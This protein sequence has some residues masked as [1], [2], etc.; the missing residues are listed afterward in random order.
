MTR[1]LL[2]TDPICVYNLYKKK[3]ATTSPLKS[4][5]RLSESS[6]YDP[7]LVGMQPPPE[8]SD[9]CTPSSTTPCTFVGAP[10]AEL[11]PGRVAKKKP[12]EQRLTGRRGSQ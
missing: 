7:R 4:E 10:H 8:R 5:T 3:S 2:T 6:R 1:F 12:G 9:V 11:L